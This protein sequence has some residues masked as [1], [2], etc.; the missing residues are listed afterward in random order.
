M[1]QFVGQRQL[2]AGSLP[3]RK[4]QRGVELRPPQMQPVESLVLL[5]DLAGALVTPMT[6]LFPPMWRVAVR[7]VRIVP[8]N[9]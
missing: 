6:R 4:L 2:S 3:A 5:L 8:P 7:A 1:E 9:R